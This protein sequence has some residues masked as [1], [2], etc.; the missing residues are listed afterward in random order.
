MRRVDRRETTEVKEA[1]AWT[2]E[3]VEKLLAAARKYEPRFAPILLFLVSTGARRGE[4]LGLKWG[5]VDF[6]RGRILIRRA[7]SH[8]ALTTPKSG[9]GRAVAM[10]QGLAEALFDLL[11]VRR[12]EALRFGWGEIPEWVFPSEVGTA[13]DERN[14]S[15]AWYRVR[16][17]AQ[18]A[19]A[20]PLKLHTARHTYASMPLASG[21][22]VRWVA[23]QLGHSSPMLTLK[24][25]AHAMREEEADLAFA[26][27]AVAD[28]PERHYA[29]PNENGAGDHI[30]NPVNTLVELRGIEPLTLRLPA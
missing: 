25:Y 26:D 15:R 17:K 19:G 24:T 3:E 30:A 2:R 18:K 27:F 9:K 16:R 29:A 1:E 13:R 7:I 23:D 14:L 8:G 11:A 22:S 6:D 12:K 5:D 28:G 21:K 10:P 20:R 4:A